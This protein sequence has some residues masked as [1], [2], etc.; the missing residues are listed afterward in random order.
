KPPQN[1]LDPWLRLHLLA[2]RLEEQYALF[3]TR[4]GVD[5][6][7]FRPAKAPIPTAGKPEYMGEG[8]YLGMAM[9][10]TVL[11][12][13]KRSQVRPFAQAYLETRG[14][15]MSYREQLRGG[16]F[17]LGIS[18]ESVRD[19]GHDLDVVLHCVLAAELTHNLCD[20]YRCCQLAVPLW[21]KQGLSYVDSRN[22]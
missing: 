16:T 9:K 11:V 5:E 4:F 2:L 21:F 6:A 14:D 8:P 17:F 19:A 15:C 7:Q 3:E 20:A 22:V 10:F 1:K 12:T 13:E 18:A